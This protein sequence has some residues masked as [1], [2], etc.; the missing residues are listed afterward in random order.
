MR[1][2]T[3]NGDFFCAML[4]PVMARIYGRRCTL[5]LELDGEPSPLPYAEE[6]IRSAR[7]GTRGANSERIGSQKYLALRLE[8]KGF[9]RMCSH[10]VRYWCGL[11]LRQEWRG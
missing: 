1:N 3:G 5:T 7:Q 4:V 9:R 6:T 2:C 11:L 8:E 10:S